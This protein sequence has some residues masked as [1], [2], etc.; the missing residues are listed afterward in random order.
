MIYV[1][2]QKGLSSYAA[3]YV[4]TAE[5]AF[6]ALVSHRPSRWWISNYDVQDTNIHPPIF[7]F[8]A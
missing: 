7:K 4:Q 5:I 3:L 8:I 2:S 6:F 1:Q